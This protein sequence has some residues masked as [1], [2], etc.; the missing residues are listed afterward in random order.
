MKVGYLMASLE[1][2]PWSSFTTKYVVWFDFQ[3]FQHTM[4]KVSMERSHLGILLATFLPTFWTIIVD[5]FIIFE[6]FP[7][8]IANEKALYEPMD[9]RTVL[10]A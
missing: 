2:P 1:S 7:P 8:T 9:Q 5:S 3:V 6:S 10:T 4:Y